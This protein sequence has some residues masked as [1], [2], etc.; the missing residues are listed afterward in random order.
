MVGIGSACQRAD[1]RRFA[2]IYD[3]PVSRDEHAA[4]IV[5]VWSLR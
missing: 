5:T 4:R 1:G 3:H 2:V